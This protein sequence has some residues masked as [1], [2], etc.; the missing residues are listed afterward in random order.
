MV[1][2]LTISP[3]WTNTLG[4]IDSASH[5]AEED[6]S[7]PQ[8]QCMKVNLKTAKNRVKA[9]GRKNNSMTGK[10]SLSSMRVSI[11]GMSRKAMGNISGLLEIFIKDT[12]RMIKDI[13]MERCTG[14]M[15]V[16]TKV[17]GMMECN[18]DMVR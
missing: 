12:T 14:M 18:M 4:N 17:N 8:G 10:K 9:V 13:S 1:M 6:I 7:G 11:R 15:G 5:G 2:E 16:Y 3:T